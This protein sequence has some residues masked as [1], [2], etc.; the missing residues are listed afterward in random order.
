MDGF[1]VLSS[2]INRME[3]EATA[4]QRFLSSSSLIEPPQHAPGLYARINLM[5][6]VAT[7]CA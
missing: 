5:Y 3:M 6:Q 4:R 7:F 2:L 1:R